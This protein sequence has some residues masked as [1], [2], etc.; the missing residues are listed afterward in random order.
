LAEL[1]NIQAFHV[2]AFIKDL[3]GEVAT[4]GETTLGRR[5]DAV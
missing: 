4:H 2:A 3:E 5:A 1:A